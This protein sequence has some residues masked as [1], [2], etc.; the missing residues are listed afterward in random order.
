MRL[1]TRYAIS[2]LRKANWLPCCYFTHLVA[3]PFVIGWSC[4]SSLTLLMTTSGG[5]DVRTLRANRH[6]TVS[7]P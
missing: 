5:V 3:T 6:N 4:C 7:L 1:E 2:T